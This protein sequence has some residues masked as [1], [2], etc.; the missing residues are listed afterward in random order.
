[1]EA[2]EGLQK[3]VEEEKRLAKESVENK[4]AIANRKKVK[5]GKAPGKS[6]SET[7]SV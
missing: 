7:V 5:K 2:D 4:R 3:I 6:G 1:V